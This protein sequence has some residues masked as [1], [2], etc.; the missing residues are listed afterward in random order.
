MYRGLSIGPLAAGIWQGVP[1]QSFDEMIPVLN[2]ALRSS[3][4]SR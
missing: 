3:P 4:N 1:S 2:P